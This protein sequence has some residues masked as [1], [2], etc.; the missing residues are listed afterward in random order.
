MSRRSGL[1]TSF[2]VGLFSAVALG[3]VWG[4]VYLSVPTST[5]SLVLNSPAPSPQP[6]TP[7]GNDTP[8]GPPQS[9]ALPSEQAIPD[10][11]TAPS[12]D[13]R[14]IHAPHPHNGASEPPSGSESQKPKLSLNLRGTGKNGHS[15]SP[16]LLPA[17]PP[18]DDV[19]A[20]RG[21]S[22][23]CIVELEKLCEGTEPGGA[24]RRCFKDKETK[25]S[26]VCQRQMDQMAARIK[27]D[28]QHFRT[29]CAGDVQ[30]LCP[31]AQPGGGSVLQCLEDNYKE[32]SENCYQALK[33]FQTRK[34]GRSL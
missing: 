15:P 18:S 13:E 17:P 24:R 11:A 34:A 16:S 20:L 3:I 29:A 21:V 7:L 25:L 31:A 4:L 12:T 6:P 23:A 14:P 33:H 8:V 2:L 30:Q 9:H 10:R 5:P 1:P 27:E 19:P 22:P 28:M 26:P 32:V